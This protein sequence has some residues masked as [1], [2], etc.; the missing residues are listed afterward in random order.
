MRRF[1]A[2]V[3]ILL[4]VAGFVVLAFSIR[5]K[6][7]FLVPVGM[8]L[9]AFLVL[10]LVRRMPDADAKTEAPKEAAGEDG[11]EKQ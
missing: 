10:L 8:I 2:W 9:A 3:G 7:H 6:V 11:N 4:A 5:W 1:L